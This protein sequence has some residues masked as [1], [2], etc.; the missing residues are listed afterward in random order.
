MILKAAR[1]NGE[2]GVIDLFL[3][4]RCVRAAIKQNFVIKVFQSFFFLYAINHISRGD[5]R[6]GNWP[7]HANEAIVK[8]TAAVS[9]NALFRFRLNS[10]FEIIQI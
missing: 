9:S 4:A 5:N 8:I 10:P 6:L 1:S 3:R 7:A 2:Y